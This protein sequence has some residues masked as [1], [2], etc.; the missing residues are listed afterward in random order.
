MG[1][2]KPTTPG[3][4]THHSA[5]ATQTA[6]GVGAHSCVLAPH[7]KTELSQSGDGKYGRMFPDLACDDCDE[8]TLLTLGSA[9]SIMDADAAITAEATDDAPH[10]NPCIPAGFPIFGQFI[11]HNI[12]ADRSLLQHH[13]NLREIRNFRT[14]SLNLESVYGAGPTGEPYLYD[15][16]DPDKLLLGV[17]D[18]G[19]PRDLPR[20]AQG[21][22]LIGDPR[23]DVHLPIAQLHLAFLTFHNA[24]VDHLRS[25]GTPAAN[26]FA[27]A[28]RLTRWH[29]QWIA[30]NEYLPLTVG[31]ALI[32]D[33]LANGRRFYQFDEQ[34][35]IPVEFSDAAYRFGHSQ[36]RTVYRLNAHAEGRIF[37]DLLGGRPVPEARVID[38]RYLFALDD[39][40]P[41][42][43]SRRIDARLTHALIALP[44]FIVGAVERPEYDS[45]ADRDLLR[46]RA[47]DLPTGE[48]I[49]RAMGVTPLTPEQ[50]GL[51]AT[52]WQYETPLWYY[53]LKEAQV[54]NDGVRLG[55]VAGRTVAETL[56]GL[57]D[58]DPTSY[59][60]AET[61]WRP[62]LP[63]AQPGTFTM[64]DLL[65]FAGL[66]VA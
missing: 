32:D 12:T 65:R 33:I 49:A 2:T 26:I 25:Q 62:T 18:A 21:R 53:T 64:A 35:F 66:G 51:R 42:Q 16:D 1:A 4:V 29:Y 39:A 40:Q 11:A 5:G 19:R 61:P 10:D 56:L 20:N 28:Q 59:R 17:N 46:G 50:V 8:A 43:S 13:T 37:P 63:A 38:W 14:P 55:P 30:A 57:L 44:E 41:P 36:I 54:L 15:N 58:G 47:L 45:L 34:P 3:N 52:G 9:G 31:Q 60:N 6:G 23:N 27:E 22:A 7:L 48:A 24:I